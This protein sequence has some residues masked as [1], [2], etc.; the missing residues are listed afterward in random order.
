M[1]PTVNLL[2]QL[3]ELTL[4]RDEQKVAPRSKGHAQQLEES[5]KAMSHE[6][7]AA[8]RDQFTK[9]YKKD[10]IAIAPV[11]DG[12]CSVCSMALPISLVQAVRVGRAVHSCPNCA[13]MLY[14]PESQ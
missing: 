7:P 8:V 6:L 9:R 4:I 2:I 3:Q 13:R 12:K 11:A 5:I 1:N 10:P 14:Y